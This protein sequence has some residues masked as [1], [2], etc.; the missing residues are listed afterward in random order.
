M[1]RHTTGFTLIELMIVV[2]IIGILSSLAIAA[3]QTYTVRAQLSEGISFASS[4]KVASVD[5]FTVT[6]GPPVGRVEAGLSPDPTDSQGTYV[7]QMDI[8]NGRVDITFGAEAHP[9]IAADTLSLTPYVSGSVVIWR[10]GN[11]PAPAGALMTDGTVSA[12]YQ[13]GTVDV[14]YLPSSCR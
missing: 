6:G 8:V 10:C 9:E 1:T 12:V 3:Y 5:T 14:R 4:V 11:A 7:S 2:A 13:P